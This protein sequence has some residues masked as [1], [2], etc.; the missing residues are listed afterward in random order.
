MGKMLAATPPMGWNSF[1]CYGAS[2]T[3]E[4]VRANALY[5]AENL[6]DYGWEYIVVDIQWYEPGADSSIY[7]PFAPLETDGYSRLVPAENRFPSAAGGQGFKPLADY[8]HGLGLKMGIHIM[9]GIPRQAVHANTPILGTTARAR[10]VA[11]PNSVCTWNTDMYGVDPVKEGAQQYYDSLFALYCQWGV[12][13]VKVD[14]IANI[15]GAPNPY[16]AMEVEMI[17]RAIDRSAREMVLSLS[18]G[19][20]RQEDFI[21]LRAHANM[22]R[23][24]CDFWDRWEDLLGA[25]A[26]CAQ[27]GGLGE[28]GRWPDADMLP[29]GHIGIRAP[30]HGMPDRFSGFTKEEQRTLVTLWCIFRSPLMIG[31]ELRD[32]DPW[33]LSLLT[34][35]EVLSVLNDS[36]RPRQLFRCGN[37]GRFVAWVSE[38]GA[39]TNLTLFN[40]GNDAQRVQV[41]LDFLHC[42]GDVAIRD[43]WARQTVGVT[44]RFITAQLPPHGCVLYRLSHAEQGI[45]SEQ[46]DIIPGRI[47]I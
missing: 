38:Y 17:R 13:F 34:N 3:E 26:S 24:T 18:P 12:D 33:T 32:M 37:E 28:P 39:E 30:E 5:M 20:S 41:P 42:H 43:L 31:G 44:Q 23:I 8:I 40:T 21:H 1:D 4:E 45:A 6:A 47:G 46:T 15:Y 27:W 10:D 11:H 14:D 19:P 16:S 36:V 35:P 22:W 2:V 25:F 29:L 9:R 7:H